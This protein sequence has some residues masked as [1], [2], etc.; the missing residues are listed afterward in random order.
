M[1]FEQ[2][3]FSKMTPE[4]EKASQLLLL[5]VRARPLRT[6][7]PLKTDRLMCPKARE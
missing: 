4:G 7:D 6:H 5:N 1:E 3:L 2:S